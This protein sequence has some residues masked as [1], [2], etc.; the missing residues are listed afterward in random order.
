MARVRRKPSASMRW[1]LEV[2][3]ILALGLALFLG[4]TLVAP[5]A[6]TGAFGGAAVFVLHFLFGVAAGLFVVLLALV[7]AIVFLEMHVPRLIATLGGP[8]CAYFALAAIP[9]AA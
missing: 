6:R 4:I 5:T 8:A 3:G 1:N 9:P 2:A 7:A